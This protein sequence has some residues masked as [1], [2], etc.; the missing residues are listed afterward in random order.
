MA[1]RDNVAMGPQTQMYTPTR[2][3]FHEKRFSE[4]EDRFNY[5]IPCLSFSRKW[6][7]VSE[8]LRDA[9]ATF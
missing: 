1:V 3:W 7:G 2:S 4:L 6:C 5:E 9:I 8:N